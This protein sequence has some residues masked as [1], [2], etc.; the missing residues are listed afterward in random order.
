MGRLSHK[1]VVRYESFFKAASWKQARP[2]VAKMEFHF[3]ELFLR[4][5]F[6]VTTFA[7]A[8]QPVVRFYKKRGTAGPAWNLCK[9]RP[10]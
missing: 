6:I 3:G 4:V 1:P 9:G 8:S 5:G 10:S 2:V 7:G